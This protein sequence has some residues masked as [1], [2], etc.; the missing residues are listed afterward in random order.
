[1][2][3]NDLDKQISENIRREIETSGLT[4]SEIARALGVSRPTVSQYVSGRIQPT[5]AMFSACAN[6]STAR[7]TTYSAC[8]DLPVRATRRRASVRQEFS[9]LRR[10]NER[11]LPAHVLHDITFTRLSR[12][13]VYMTKH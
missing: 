3:T 6:A 8:T 12:H 1:M 7:R 11:A 2:E 4:K 10:R 9:A 13:Y 5:L